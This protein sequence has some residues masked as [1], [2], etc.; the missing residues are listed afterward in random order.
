MFFLHRYIYLYFMVR[1]KEI[2]PIV[3]QVGERISSIIK[4]NN[5]KVR[6]VAH[7]CDMD[8]V[9]LRRYINGK[10]IM[11]IDKIYRI[12]QALGVEV[13]ILFKQ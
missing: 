11:G 12:A 6:H 4:E 9:T 1:Q 3:L 2:A 10:Q 8:E 13:G 5:L 7:D